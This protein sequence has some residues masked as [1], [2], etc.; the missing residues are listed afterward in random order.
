MLFLSFLLHNLKE[1]FLP[2]KKTFLKCCNDIDDFLIKF[3]LIYFF[4]IDK[5]I[6]LSQS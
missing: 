3:N 4:F 6:Y 1:N 5:V 2:L